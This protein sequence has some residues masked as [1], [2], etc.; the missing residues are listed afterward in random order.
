MWQSDLHLE[1]LD[2]SGRQ[3]LISMSVPP[4]VQQFALRASSGDADADGHRF[5]VYR[6]R[7]KCEYL[8]AELRESRVS[9]DVKKSK[10]DNELSSTT[11]QLGV[12]NGFW[13]TGFTRFLE[14][15]YSENRIWCSKNAGLGFEN[16]KLTHFWPYSPYSEI[17]F[18]LNQL[19]VTPL[20]ATKD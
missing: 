5:F 1:I 14:P 3:P 2:I 17:R 10:K 18:Y 13:K 7:G 8:A 12:W 16:T 20:P 9:R 6:P 11:V 19:F 4:R 15:N